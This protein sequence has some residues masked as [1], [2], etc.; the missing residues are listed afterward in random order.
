MKGVAFD[1]GSFGNCTIILQDEE[2]IESSDLADFLFLF[3]GVYA[4]GIEVAKEIVAL[5]KPDPNFLAQEI[6]K[7]IQKL[8]VSQIDALFTQDLGPNR[9]LTERISRGS[10]FEIVLCGS[11][12]LIVAAIILSGGKVEFSEGT[13]RATLPPLGKGI[14]FLREALTSRTRTPIGYGVKSK[15][16]QLS[17]KELALLMLQDPTKKDRGGFQSFLVGL[18]MRVDQRTRKLELSEK[19]M[20]RISR[21]TENRKKGG[22]QARIYK[23]FG[24]HFGFNESD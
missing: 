3:R 19:D 2:Q 9:L 4:A 17:K 6:H 8:T 13:L 16:V 14:K 21:A 12:I 22:F 23:I 18:Q 24:K 5:K 10:P 20:D 15:T 11:L 1:Y 7:H